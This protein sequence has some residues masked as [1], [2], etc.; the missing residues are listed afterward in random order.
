MK[1]PYGKTALRCKGRAKRRGYIEDFEKLGMGIFVHY[2]LY[3]VLG[4]GEWAR[5]YLGVD[6]EIC[7]KL[8]DKFMPSKNW[9]KNL[10][11]TAKRAGAK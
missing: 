2:G 7:E 3:S 10:V 11:S 1:S 4:K 6:K 5:H 9:A 8:A